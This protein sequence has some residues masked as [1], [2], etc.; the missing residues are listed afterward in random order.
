MKGVQK[1]VGDSKYSGV[2]THY[3][4][5]DGYISKQCSVVVFL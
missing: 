3:F 1:K 2:L 4:L 5:C